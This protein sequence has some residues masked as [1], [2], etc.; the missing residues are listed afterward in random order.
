MT[1]PSDGWS[2]PGGEAAPPPP[3]YGPP[4]PGYGPPPPGYG[5]PFA[6]GPTRPWA[7]V[8][9]VVP[10]RPLGLGELLDGSLKIVRRYPKPT[11]GL[12]AAIA[13]V[14]TAIN[15]LLVVLLDAGVATS[16]PSEDVGAQ[17]NDGLA[18]SAA[19]GP[20]AVIAY[21]AGLVLSGGL[22]VVVGKA[23]LGQDVGFAEVWSAVRP[24]LWALL[25]LSLLT[26]LLVA[27]PLVVAVVAILAL[28][29]AGALLLLAG[30]PATV[31][32]YTRL[33]LAPAALVLERAGVT[34][35]LRRSGVLVRGSWWRVFGVLVLTSIIGSV[36][37]GIITIPVGVV[38]LVLGGDSDATPLLVAT[39][40]ASGLGSIVVAPFTAGVRA[41][42][43][44]DQRMRKEG[45]DV[46][47][48]AA[49]AASPAP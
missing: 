11:L 14:V 28:G 39:Q 42:L 44:V 18:S 31:Y 29:P 1:E 48:Q 20:G 5:A 45:L 43:Y 35:A 13:V 17:F 16:T 47:L 21:L 25:G 4:P 9:G 22:V 32:L 36:L 38:A 24:R 46:A 19:S 34:T 27:A 15:V 12:A 30:I 6:Y 8:P 26:G 10:L 37:S 41:L 23:V 40:V 33:S 3:G 7:P 2:S 49:V